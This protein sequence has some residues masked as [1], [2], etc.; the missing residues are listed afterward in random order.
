MIETVV[1]VILTLSTTV[2]FLIMFFQTH[3]RPRTK[4]FDK[5]IGL[6]REFMR[7]SVSRTIFDRSYIFHFINNCL[8]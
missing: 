3:S 6:K 1:C 5:A 7:C 2:L 8:L 4:H